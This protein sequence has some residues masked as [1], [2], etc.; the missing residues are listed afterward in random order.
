MPDAAEHPAE[1][2]ADEHARRLAREHRTRRRP[3]GAFYTPDDLV[4]WVL[5][6]A[7]PTPASGAR[8]LDPACGTGHFLVAAARRVGVAGVHGSDLDADA[9]AIARRR[10]S[11]LDP[12]VS[13]EQLEQQ[14]VVADGL[15]HWRGRRFDAV[16]GNPPFLG[17]LRRDTGGRAEPGR[18]ALG[19]YTDTS[20]VFLHAALDL[21]E[22]GGTVALV[23]PL[24]L[25]AARDAGPVRER[26]LAAGALTDFWTTPRP[27]FEGTDV[28]CCVP[29]V[30]VG[31]PVGEGLVADPD[32]WGP[33]AAEAFGIPAV[34]LL[35]PSG[36]GA[37][38]RPGVVGDLATCSADFRDQYYG[39]A[40]HVREAGPDPRPGD[41]TAVPLVTVGLIDPAECRWGVAEARFARRSWQA[42]V[43]DVEALAAADPR[44]G[45]WARGRLV[46][47]L[48]VA[49]QGRVLEAVVDREGA[50][51]PS[52]PL[53][54][55]VPH[56]G[57]EVLWRLLAL[58]LAPPLVAHAAARHLGAGLS[59][60]AVKLSAR[61]VAALPLP[62]DDEA[63]AAGAALA[64]RAQEAPA[65]RRP[66]ALEEVART[67]TTAYLPDAGA[68]G[69]PEADA[70]LAWWLERRAAQRPSATR[71]R[72]PSV[73][74]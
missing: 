2:A 72:P 29:V 15:E 4:A 13:P 10:L 23:Q 32:R 50:W 64:R 19:A 28:L 61:Q 73:P 36:A 46:P 40:P 12:T 27:V 31:S 66:R 6:R 17:Q 18:R 9:V 3:M 65:E 68:G 60:G 71:T 25:L 7:L 42:P 48:L 54:S 59:A 52:V 62:A 34:D 14:V 53:V 38:D 67:M 49:G 11:A 45:A 47:K 1:L 56:G 70:A 35:P 33:L 21:V 5:D 63:W 69:S 20:A 44:L 30:R 26:V 51:L 24:S 41:G 8:V 74:T 37:E 22:P 55:V 43:V 58:T 57:P 16:V 39:L